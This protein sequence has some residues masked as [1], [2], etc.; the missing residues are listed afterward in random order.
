[1]VWHSGQD[2]TSHFAEQSTAYTYTEDGIQ[3]SA[4]ELGVLVSVWESMHMCGRQ[5]INSEEIARNPRWFLCTFF[6]NSYIVLYS[7]PTIS[8]ETSELS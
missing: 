7:T 2:Y 1:M 8:E 6:S 4:G 5:Y 3:L